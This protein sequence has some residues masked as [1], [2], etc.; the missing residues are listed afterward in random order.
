MILLRLIAILLVIAGGLALAFG[1]FSYTQEKTALKAGPL[2][3]KVQ[4]KET[5]TIPPWAGGGAIALGVVL[6]LVGGRKR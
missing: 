5:V 6:L 1:S 3:L 2:E 4:D